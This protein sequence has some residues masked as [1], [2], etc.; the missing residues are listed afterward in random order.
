MHRQ[1]PATATKL[2]EA[3]LQEMFAHGNDHISRLQRDG[4]APR[5][6]IISGPSG[7]GKDSVLEHLQAVYPAARYV[8]TS[9]SRP[10]RENERDGVHYRF[11]ERTVFEQQ[12]EAGEYIESEEVYGNLYGV[13]RRPI[14]EGLANGQHVIIKVDV[15]GAST[16]RDKIKPTT[17]IFLAPETME[18]LLERLRARKTD[19]WDVLMRRF[20]TASEELE[21]AEEFDYVV[22]NESDQLPVAVANI[23]HIIDAAQQRIG[24]HSVS[25]ESS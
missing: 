24:A 4:R 9:T 5:V 8:V 20:R 18:K 12:I 14:L 15:K 19:N 11:L 21:R 22:F 16:L 1:M 6:F 23:C 3:E 25:V 2:T 7:V 10:V 17:S 13:P